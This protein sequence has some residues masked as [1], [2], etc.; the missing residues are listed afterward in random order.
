MN[1]A[2]RAL[3]GDEEAVLHLRDNVIPSCLALML[4]RCNDARSRE[5]AHEIADDLL[6]EIVHVKGVRGPRKNILESYGGRA[7]LK[8]W[9]QKIAERKLQDWWKSSRGAKEGHL[10]DL[11]GENGSVDHWLKDETPISADPEAM[12]IAG[13][14]LRIAVAR[15]EPMLWTLT[16]LTFVHGVEKQRLALVL[17]HD[18]ATSGRWIKEAL[19][20]IKEVYDE[21]VAA[22][23][24]HLKVTLADF[25]AASQSEIGAAESFFDLPEDEEEKE[26]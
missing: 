10:E 7:S 26:E 6:G 17:K 3:A 9:F 21:E 25:L 13:E 1:L 15:L 12:R 22:R 2:K 11:A 4:N 8:T 14:A 24:P 16:Q 20:N 5:Q 23:D 19:K 18:N